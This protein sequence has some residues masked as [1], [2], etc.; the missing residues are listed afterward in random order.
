MTIADSKIC[1]RCSGAMI[2]HGRISL[3]PQTIYRCGSCG[4]QK[5]AAETLPQYRPQVS[6]PVEQPEAQQQQQPQI[7]PF[8]KV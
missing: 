8:D 6:P 5:W 1:D 2:F 3:P 4:N 7:K